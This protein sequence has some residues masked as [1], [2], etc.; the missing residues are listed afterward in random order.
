LTRALV[1]IAEDEPQARDALR[2]LLEDEG[3]R[4]LTA[5]DGREAA[6]LL[7]VEAVDAAVL[8]IRMPEKDGLA[9][10]RELRA[11]EDPPPVL[12]MTAYGNSSVAI[13]AMA[14][15]AFDYL[16]KPLNFSELI[17]QLERAIENR[18]RNRDLA[19]YRGEAPQPELV[20]SSD[21]MR[22]V[23]KLIGQV[24][25]SDSTVLIRGESGTGKELIAR[26]IHR[27]SLRAARRLVTVNCA[28][29]PEPLL[30]AELLGHERGAFTGAAQRRTGK[31][32]YAQGGAIFLDE[33][34]EMTPNTQA[35][36]LRVLQERSIERLGSNVTIQL[37]VRVIA[38][39]SRD[40]ERMVGE[41]SFREDL[42]YRLNV[43]TIAAPPLRER[44][45]DIPELV[46]ALL[47]RIAA[48]LK[49]P[50][51]RIAPEA[52][53]HLQRQSWPGNV[54]ELE[55]AIERAVVLHRG[56]ALLPEHFA[57]G[58]APATHPF[59]AAPLD[60]GFH[61]LV[62]RL[63]RR[64]IERALLEAGGNRSRAAEIL[65]I[66]RRLLYDKIREFGLE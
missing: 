26:A 51:P 37:D 47:C 14:L 46:Q 65:K 4:V 38:A 20:G 27:H 12:M 5:R 56:G 9:V 36:L 11:E 32:E 57:Q 17:I 29:I 1:L 39:T 30:E 54:R 42:F 50:I 63:E 16:T 7:A 66:H 2:E 33:I 52:V 49:I 22:R 31:L 62:A 61:A 43:V 18:R 59:D 13:E 19:A 44:V 40:L 58:P 6:A 34:G 41:G 21:L 10:L 53:D 48:R 3:Y 60:E 23:Y 8:D 55:H 15:G 45:E 35:K 28:S 64:L 25:P 24:A